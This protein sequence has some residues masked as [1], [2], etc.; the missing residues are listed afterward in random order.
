[1]TS[2]ISIWTYY[3]HRVCCSE[4]FQHHSMLLGSPEFTDHAKSCFTVPRYCPGLDRSLP[5]AFQRK[6]FART[7]LHTWHSLHLENREGS[8]MGTAGQSLLVWKVERKKTYVHW[9]DFCFLELS[10]KCVFCHSPPNQQVDWVLA[11]TNSTSFT[12]VHQHHKLLCVWWLLFTCKTAAGCLSRKILHANA[13]I[14]KNKK[15]K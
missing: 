9:L 4:W 6:L 12:P 15:I 3:L 2:V 10:N 11:V 5:A 1:M 14:C 8:A 13:T 7:S